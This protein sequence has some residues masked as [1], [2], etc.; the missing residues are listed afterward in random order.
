MFVVL[1][2]SAPM[3]LTWSADIR[4]MPPHSVV[5]KYIR[6]LLAIASYP[7]RL[8]SNLRHDYHVWFR[9]G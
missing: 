8:I 7:L 2:L 6:Y 4:D 3:Q 1:T 9:E 5:F